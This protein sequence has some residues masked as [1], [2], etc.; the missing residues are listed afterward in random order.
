MTKWNQCFLEY[1]EER[2]FGGDPEGMLKH[3]SKEYPGGI[4]S[5]YI[6]WRMGKLSA[7]RGQPKCEVKKYTGLRPN[8]VC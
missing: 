2:G 8:F 6:C 1:C 7:S 4:M 3:D 5:G